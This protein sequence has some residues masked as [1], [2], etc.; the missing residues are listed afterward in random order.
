MIIFIGAGKI[1]E[2]YGFVLL[3]GCWCVIVIQ[4]AAATANASTLSRLIPFN[5]ENIL[6]ILY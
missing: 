6:E 3:S 5:D 4:E 2:L 1:M